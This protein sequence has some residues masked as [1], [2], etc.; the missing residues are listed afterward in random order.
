MT[1]CNTGTNKSLLRPIFRDEFDEMTKYPKGLRHKLIII[2]HKCRSTPIRHL[3][4]EMKHLIF[5][6][7]SRVS[8]YFI[9]SHNKLWTVRTSSRWAPAHSSRLFKISFGSSEKQKL[10]CNSFLKPLE[11]FFT[12]FKSVI[13]LLEEN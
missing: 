7:V 2:S 10:S 6:S 1:Q 12:L 3:T 8:F 4:L 5:L 9:F 13:T 11:N